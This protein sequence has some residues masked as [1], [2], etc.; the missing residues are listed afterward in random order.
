MKKGKI[1]IIAIAILVVVGVI[2]FFVKPKAVAE[3]T[4]I[5]N[6]EII[7]EM[8]VEGYQRRERID[9]LIREVDTI[10]L[11]QIRVDSTTLDSMLR[12]LRGLKND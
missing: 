6:I 9:S 11:R 8:Q 12:F 3:Q 10:R 2:L 7:E 4:S 5:T 1:I